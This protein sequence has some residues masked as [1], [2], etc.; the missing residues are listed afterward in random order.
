MQALLSS[1]AIDGVELWDLPDA[2]R[3]GA[4]VEAP[5]RL[6][7]EFDNLILS[8][9][10]RRRVVPERDRTRLSTRNGMQPATVL[11]DGTVAGTW[12]AAANNFSATYP[13]AI[14]GWSFP[15]YAALYTVVLNFLIA[16]VMTPVFN[17]MASRPPVDET[18]A[19]DYLR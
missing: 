11:L 6:L 1:G 3:P 17:A 18:V 2:P 12:I 19:A 4:D 16:L 14:G 7:G 8:H 5:V 9:A 10:D 15:G 13:L